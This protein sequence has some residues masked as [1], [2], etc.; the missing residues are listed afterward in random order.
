[1]QTDEDLLA[2]VAA[3]DREA[4]GALFRRRQLDVYRFALHM[5]GEPA[6]ADDVT[7]EVFVAVMHDAA[8]YEPG[9]STVAAWLCGIARNHARRRLERDRRLVAFSGDDEDV[10][11]GGATEGNPLADL[12]RAE[13]L[14]ALRRAVLSLP[15]RYR[16][17]VIACDL[18][19]L[20]YAE[21]AEA[22]GCALGTVRSRLF[23]GR[24]LLASKLGASEQKP[25]AEATVQDAHAPHPG[26]ARMIAI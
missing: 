8:R 12:T 7:Q 14:D 17:A 4:F 13:G 6:V 22:L 24:A 3:G 21:A 26:R 18:Q 11:L 19:E 25:A 1:M 20:T 9:R 2:A 23:R 10:P 15:L 5:T 16:E